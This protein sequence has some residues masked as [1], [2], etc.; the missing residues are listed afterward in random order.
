MEKNPTKPSADASAAPP[1]A[2]RRPKTIEQHGETRV[3][4]YSWLRDKDNAE[5]RAYLEA[6]NAWT[7]AQMRDV[8]PIEEQIYQE[9]VGRIQETDTSAPVRVGPWLY[10]SR[11]VAGKQYRIYC[12]RPVASA[13]ES[14]NDE[15]VLL[16]ANALAE[17]HAYFQ[18]GVFEVSPDDNLLAWST[19]TSGDEAFTIFVKDLRTG[20]VLGD[21]I[22]NTYYSLEW[23]ADS[24]T[25]FYN[26]LDAA[27]RPFKVFRHALGTEATADAEVYHETDE[28]FEVDITRTRDRAY[29]LLD[30]HSHTTSEAR[31]LRSSHP[32]DAFEPLIPRVQGVE[33]E[34][35]HHDGRWYIRTSDNARN[36][37]LISAPAGDLA[38]ENWREEI[39]A[40]EG[41]TIEVVDAL[42]RFLVVTERSD[43]LQQIRIR[44]FATGAE[45][46]VALPEPVYSVAAEPDGD[47]DTDFLRLTYSSLRTPETAYDYD[48]RARALTV[49]KR[50]PVLGGFDPENYVSERL[51]ATAPDGVRVPVSLVYRKGWKKDAPLRTLLYG[52]GAYGH[53]IDAAFSSIRFSLLDRGFICAIAHIRGGGD[54]GKEWH[55]AGRM[56]FKTNTFADFIAAAEAL[57]G[58]GYTTP[59]QLA[60]LG[61]SAGGLL[62][63]AV[64]NL[65]PDLFG[66]AIAKV[67]FVDV[68][69]TMS[70]ATLPLTIGEYEEWGNP[71]DFETYR[72]LRAYAPYENVR[73]AAYPH[74]LVTAGL[75]DPRVGY[76]EPAKWVAKLRRLNKS[77]NLLLLKTT[78]GA[79]H[80]GASGRYER[81]R[82]TAFEYAFLLK[83]LGAGGSE[84]RPCLEP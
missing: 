3:D 23:A 39:A 4:D 29:I 30:I 16:D 46:Y 14:E 81:F 37:R 24:R 78:M 71:E 27:R 1:V 77:T 59:N 72:R 75:N 62:I 13:P 20:E 44:E 21:R 36:F 52:Y 19:D 53:S 82:E 50:E 17:G 2:A 65:R 7:S 12:R 79:G 56:A 66:V 49:V 68:L 25:F 22:A 57:I 43:A 58:A 15:Q 74:L 38:R 61:G 64:L 32:Q 8:R 42:A 55:E 84:P 76:W 48:M 26:V 28:R 9:L 33:M 51:Y 31:A 10:Y 5:V 35:T 45:H 63:G 60:I 69:N 34:A 6:E 83:A 47:Y 11:T 80:F 54:L 18:L 73:A 70:D 40:R 41:V 67:P